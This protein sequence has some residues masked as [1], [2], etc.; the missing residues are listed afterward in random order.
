MLCGVFWGSPGWICASE[1]SFQ[2]EELD[3]G[4]IAGEASGVQKSPVASDL[5]CHVR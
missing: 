5:S 1:V 2:N 4:E 3:A